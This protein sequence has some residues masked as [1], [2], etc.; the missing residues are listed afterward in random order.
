METSYS[1]DEEYRSGVRFQPK[2]IFRDGWVWGL[3][4]NNMK[5][6]NAGLLIAIEAI[7]KAGMALRGDVLFVGWSARSRRRRR[8]SFKEPNTQGRAWA[9]SIWYRTA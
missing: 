3:D 6:G 1:G 2:R 9:Q 7:A 5:S 8:K 4:A